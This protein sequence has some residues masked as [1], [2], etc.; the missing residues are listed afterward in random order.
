MRLASSL[1]V[2]VAGLTLGLSQP[3]HTAER[4]SG[5]CAAARVLLED[6]FSRSPPEKTALDEAS[7]GK[8]AGQ[9]VRQIAERH[10]ASFATDGWRSRET[11]AVVK[12]P[13]AAAI[14][15][16]MAARHV[17]ATA[18]DEV[19]LDAGARGALLG[20]SYAAV[21]P[22]DGVGRFTRALHTISRPVVSPD[23][24]EALA[25]FSEGHAPLAAAGGLVLLR[26]SR[27]GAWKIAG[28]LSLWIS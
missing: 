18:C 19:R 4:S 7:A 25:Y 21:A 17:S 11:G 15:A 20:A 14:K 2:A 26:K 16:F 13:S 10:G 9:F 22:A 5:A 8:G 3:A 12:P 1:A 6:V 23:G 24:T 27:D 28:H